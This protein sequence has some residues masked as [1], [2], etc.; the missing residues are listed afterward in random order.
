M[1]TKKIA[2]T[3]VCVAMCAILLLS[4]CSCMKIGM[5]ENTIVD[6]LQDAGA[7]VRYERSTPMTPIGAGYNLEDLI[8]ATLTQGEES[9]EVWT[10]YVICAGDERA[11]D[12]AEE[13]CKKYVADNGEETVGWNTYRYERVILCGHY[14]LLAIARGY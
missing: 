10:L 1:K 5:K 4:L 14:K 2:L 13:S 6:R 9:E 12:W 3:F 11:A 7:S 8:L